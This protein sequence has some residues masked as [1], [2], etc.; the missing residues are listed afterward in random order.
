MN[1]LINW[2]KHNDILVEDEFKYKESIND[3]K[4]ILDY[5]SNDY[6]ESLSMSIHICDSERIKELN[7]EHRGKDSSTDVLSFPHGELDED[8]NL[9]YIGD[10]FINEDIIESQAAEINS[11]PITELKFLAMHGMLHLVGYDH[12]NQEDEEE[13]TSKQ[14]EI[15][16][17]LNIRE[18]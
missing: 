16:I 10:I 2:Y 5:I 14:R 6:D 4:R 8:D 11:D 12:L 13:M 18:W 9:L 15:F 1:N 3:I 17:K 7:R